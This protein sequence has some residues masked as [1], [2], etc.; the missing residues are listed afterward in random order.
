MKNF[1]SEIGFKTARSSGSGGQNVNKVETMVTA[2]WHVDSSQFFDE[3]EKKLILEKLKNKINTKGYLLVSSQEFRTQGENKENA[4]K[5]ILEMV[6]LAIFV[7]KKRTKTK[8]TK[9]SIEKRIQQKKNLAEKK[10]RRN[11]R[12]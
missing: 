5:K 3:D 6:N 11:F 12:F 4:I 8:P 10:Q 2:K 7:P 9:S 1:T